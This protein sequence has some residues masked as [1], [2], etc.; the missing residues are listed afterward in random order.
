MTRSIRIGF[1]PSLLFVVCGCL[2][3]CVATAY[4]EDLFPYKNPGDPILIVVTGQSNAAQVFKSRDPMERNELIRDWARN[5]ESGNQGGEGEGWH[6]RIPDPNDDV[7]HEID[8]TSIIT[9]YPQ[10]RRGGIA[11]GLADS[12]SKMTGRRVYMVC[13]A[14]AGKAIIHWKPGEGAVG[15]ELDRQVGD[16]LLELQGEYPDVRFADI[17]VWAQGESDALLGTAPEDYAAQWLAWRDH[18]EGRNN[19]APW[20]N[21]GHTRWFMTQVSR[22][23]PRLFAWQ[24]HDY[25]LG[26]A[27][28]RLSQITSRNKQTIDRIHFW[29]DEATRFG[30]EVAAQLNRP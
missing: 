20:A 23:A 19:P 14:Q 9:G 11:W 26:K 7:M 16:A 17:V 28:G 29:G 13:T 10:G 27:A 2:W 18:V 4:A 21:S 24:G 6:W 8:L 5:I 12:L 22:D 3:F 25:L 15:L 30:S 1:F